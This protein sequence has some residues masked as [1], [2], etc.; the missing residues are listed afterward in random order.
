MILVNVHHK[1]INDNAL[2]LHTTKA[3]KLLSKEI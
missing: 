1:T 2:F 3:F